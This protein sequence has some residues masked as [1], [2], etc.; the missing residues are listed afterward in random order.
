MLDFIL[1]PTPIQRR[2][3]RSLLVLAL[4]VISYL[5]FSQPSYS[6]PMPHFDKVG[7]FVAFFGLAA[8]LQWAT[9][10]RLG[11]QL[12]L[13][14]GYALM[15]ELVQAQLPYRVADPADLVADMAGALSFYLCLMGL[16]LWSRRSVS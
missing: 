10:A 6:A 2:L 14:F 1:Q 5:V 8:L 13:L 3:G 11:W 16:R 4:M 12:T 9:N 15:I 7:H